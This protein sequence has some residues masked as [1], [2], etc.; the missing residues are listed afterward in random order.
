MIWFSVG[1]WNHAA[2]PLFIRKRIYWHG[3]RWTPFVRLFWRYCHMR[4]HESGDHQ[5]RSKFAFMSAAGSVNVPMPVRP[6]DH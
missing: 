4:Q 1:T 3:W 2:G 5:Y 6:A